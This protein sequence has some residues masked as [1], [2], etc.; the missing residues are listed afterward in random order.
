MINKLIKSEDLNIILIALLIHALHLITY[1][2]EIVY[3][4][5]NGVGRVANI[6]WYD[7]FTLEIFLNWVI[8]IF[9]LA[10]IIPI[11][12]FMINKRISWLRTIIFQAFLAVAFSPIMSFIYILGLASFGKV[13]LSNLNY[14]VALRRSINAID[15]NFR[16]YIVFAAIVY[17]Y[18]YFKKNTQIELEQASLKAELATTKNK[19]LTSQLQPHFLFNTLNSI[20]SLMGKDIKKSE[21]ML[22]DLSGLLR[23]LLN[24]KDENLIELQDEMKL[25]YRYINII[26]TRFSDDL[27]LEVNI[28]TNLENTLIPSMLIQPVIE[29]SIKHGYS[30]D[31]IKLWVL[32]E[33]YREGKN[34][35]ILVKN[36]GKLLQQPFKKLISNGLGVKNTVERLKTL[37]GNNNFKYEIYNSEIGVTTKITIPYEIAKFELA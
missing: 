20:Q 2:I 35:I 30:R 22:V 19:I 9:V 29:N 14:D 12:K 24:N 37:Y 18:Y 3:N 15:T 16:L 7:I 13:D 25:V 33:I 28:A 27:K 31:N 4:K 34:T 23:E 21:L 32:L 6:S 17:L 11:T 10:A 8:M 1:L 26:K 5:S 36:N